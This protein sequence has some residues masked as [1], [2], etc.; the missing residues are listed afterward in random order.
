MSNV[1]DFQQASKARDLK[2]ILMFCD[3]VETIVHHEPDLEVRSNKLARVER[4][5][6]T[7]EQA[8]A[9]LKGGA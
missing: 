5:R 8:L 6:Q 9:K 1:Q 3:A 4:T 2:Q 7:A